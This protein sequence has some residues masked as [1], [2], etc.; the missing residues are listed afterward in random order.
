MDRIKKKYIKD[1]NFHVD[2]LTEKELKCLVI[3]EVLEPS[4]Y[5]SYEPIK[6]VEFLLET[7]HLKKLSESQLLK[8]KI[9][10]MNNKEHLLNW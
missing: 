4:P 10:N 6:D 1:V 7:R 8:K 5:N 3:H 2:W 9:L